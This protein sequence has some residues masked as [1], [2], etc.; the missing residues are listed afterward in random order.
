MNFQKNEI[1]IG[2]FGCAAPF[3][4]LRQRRTS[5]CGTIDYLSPEM[6]TGGGKISDPN[7]PGQSIY[8]GYDEKCDIWAYG[9]LSYEILTGKT[10]FSS[11]KEK[12]MDIIMGQICKVIVNNITK[13]FINSSESLSPL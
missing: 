11:K 6:V 2:D 5:F 13:G 12:N 4:T 1:K 9:V 10:P 8:K 7:D 3:P